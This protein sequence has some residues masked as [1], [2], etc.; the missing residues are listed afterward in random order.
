[1][2]NSWSNYK[3]IKFIYECGAW[4]S[5]THTHTNALKTEMTI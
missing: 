3:L 4:A 1:L 5:N 2:C